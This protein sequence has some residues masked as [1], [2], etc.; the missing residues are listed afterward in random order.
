MNLGGI[1]RV[2][3]GKREP[4]ARI[5]GRGC[6]SGVRGTACRQDPRVLC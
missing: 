4:W 3:A 2:V 5:A 6:R 1:S